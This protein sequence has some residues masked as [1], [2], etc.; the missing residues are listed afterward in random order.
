MNTNELTTR[1]LA[2]LTAAIAT[3]LT[4]SELATAI[5]LHK[6]TIQRHLQ[7]LVKAGQVKADGRR[8]F[9]VS[10]APASEP[11]PEQA[12]PTVETAVEASAP[13]ASPEPAPQPVAKKARKAKKGTPVG[14]FVAPTAEVPKAERADKALEYLRTNPGATAHQVAEALCLCGNYAPQMATAA[15]T[16]LIRRGA[17]TKGTNDKG[18]TIY[19]AN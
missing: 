6:R 11:T 19:S 7:P 13:E 8:Y 1:I 12:E 2:T 3:G 10:E 5:G 18:A 15:L 14:T 9:I 17:A 16:Q 4:S